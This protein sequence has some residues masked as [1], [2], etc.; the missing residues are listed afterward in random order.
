MKRIFASVYSWF[1]LILM[2]AGEIFV[3]F[4]YAWRQSGLSALVW[5]ICGFLA[6]CILAP[7]LHE[8]GHILFARSQGMKI[9]ITKFSFFR[10]L[11]REGKLRFSLASPFRTDQTQA[12]PLRSGN[13]KKRA[14]LYTIGGL[15]F[16][17]I[18]AFILLLFAL[19]LQGKNIACFF[20]G[21]FPYAAYLFL[22]NAVPFAY[23]GGKTDMLIF[24]GIKRELP[25]E[26]AMLCAMEIYGKLYEGKSF[27]EI[28]RGLYY[29]FPQLA[30]DEPMY[31]VMLDLCY[32]YHIEKGE[33]E[34][35]ADSLNRLA[36][37]SSYLSEEEF[38]QTAAELV[39][40]HS[41][42]GDKARAEESGKLAERY[43]REETPSAS[44]ILAAYAAFCGDGERAKILKERAERLLSEEPC[45]GLR[46]FEK[47]LLERIR[48]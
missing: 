28:E 33:T 48:I 26:K 13:M 41:L 10:F 34:R 32:R 20:W 9:K 36:S 25:A 2:A 38:S 29:D 23:S 14:E 1:L 39:Y 5:T 12:I 22:L 31:A 6:A 30:E 19:L 24:C 11:E 37:A 18:Y 44:R 7:T 4:F 17:G 42:V 16:G 21:G 15:V 3:A 27:S 46:R 8:C 47:I 45:E 40:M 35:A 43:L